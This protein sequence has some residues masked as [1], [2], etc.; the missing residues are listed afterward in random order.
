MRRSGGEVS[1]HIAPMIDVVFLLLV[2]F[3]V[4]TDFSPAEEVFRMDLP[5]AAGGPADTLDLH[6][7]PLRI[8]LA[9]AGAD[10]G[11]VRIRVAGPWEVASSVEGLRAFLSSSVVPNGSLFLADH[12]IIIAPSDAVAWGHVVAAFNAA[13]ASGCTNITL[14][15]PA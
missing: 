1:L 3:M 14:E 4:A 2:Y 8:T 15:P 12:P 6:D 9:A 13:A 7:E 11:G 10:G 5:A